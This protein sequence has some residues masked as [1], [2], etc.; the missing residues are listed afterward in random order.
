M[1]SFEIPKQL[2]DRKFY[3]ILVEKNGKKPT[4]IA[5]TTP[6]NSLYFD[7]DELAKH[8]E[9]GGNYGILTG[10]GLIVIDADKKELQDRI[11][12]I[13]PETFT[14]KTPR[15]NGG[16]HYYFFNDSQKKILIGKGEQH[17][18]ELQ[19]R[20]QQIICA[21][22]QREGKK[23]EI[24]KD[25]P[26]ASITDEI[27][28]IAIAPWVEEEKIEP[29]KEQKEFD[30]LNLSIRE[31]IPLAKMKRHGNEYYGEHPIHGSETGQN[32]WVN[33]S[34]NVWHCFRCDSGGGVLQWLAVQEGLIT[35]DKAKKN[36]LKGQV[37][38]RLKEIVVEKYGVVFPKKEN[39][40]ENLLLE[41]T[42]NTNWL[43]FAD[44]F[45]DNNGVYYDNQ[46]IW[47]FWNKQKYCWEMVDETDIMNMVDKALAHH[48][49]TVQ[50]NIKA[51]IIEALKRKARLQ[52][53]EE[54]K[55]DWVQFK[56]KIVDVINGETFESTKKYFF[57]NP[58]P[59]SIGETEETPE[60]DKLF[61]E[62]VGKE[63]TQ[64]L[65]EIIAFCLS[66]RYFIHTIFCFTGSGSNG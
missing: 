5:W 4:S 56:D 48:P 1:I 10:H 29:T 2:Q 51:Q 3:F 31:Y 17:V 38:R 57:T 21:G 63:Q 11:E 30:N 54:P 61:E 46:K 28:K 44:K 27:I 37:F 47:W 58:I 45:V 16:K 43:G 19:A 42:N 8:I 24:I 39:Q 32:F 18:G 40:I 23:Y 6:E 15:E 41:L 9:E 59:W 33:T 65:Y 53:P 49:L 55:E 22:S 7:N 13:L 35:C 12:S 20:G 34:K 14:V 25:L 60:M 66:T 36:C 62:W 52:K 50:I 64:M 26:I